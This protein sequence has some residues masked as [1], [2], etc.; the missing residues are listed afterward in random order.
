MKL[1]KNPFV[2]LVMT[3]SI[4]VFGI[5]VGSIPDLSIFVKIGV[6]SASGILAT[7]VL[8]SIIPPIKKDGENRQK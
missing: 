7:T 3:V 6:G 5:V 1:P 2:L 8:F 4:L